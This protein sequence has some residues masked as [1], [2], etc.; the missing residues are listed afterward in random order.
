MTNEER[1]EKRGFYQQDLQKF[2]D[3]VA[4]TKDWDTYLTYDQLDCRVKAI[5]GTIEGFREQW[6]NLNGS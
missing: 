2:L 6:A 1:V 3:E 4:S 5:E